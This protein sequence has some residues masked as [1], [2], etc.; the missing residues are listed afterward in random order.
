LISRIVAETVFHEV[1]VNTEGFLFTTPEDRYREM[2][3]KHPN[4]FNAAPLY[5][6][7]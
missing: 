2:M 4:I 3:E 5:H 1:M 6:I 7:A